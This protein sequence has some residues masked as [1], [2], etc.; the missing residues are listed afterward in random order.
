[1]ECEACRLSFKKFD[2]L[3]ER[4]SEIDRL[5]PNCGC[6]STSVS[7]FSPGVVSDDEVLIRLVIA[8]IHGTS[9]PKPAALQTAETHGLSVFRKKYVSDTE[10]RKRAEELVSNAREGRPKSP[11]SAGLMSVIEMYAGIIRSCSVP[12]ESTPSFCVYDT[13][14]HDIPSHA[15]AFQRMHDVQIAIKS[16]RRTA[17]FNLVKS[18]FVPVSEYR[19]GLLADLAPST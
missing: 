15:E 9:A 13:A 19:Q 7:Q 5:H 4:V 16:L 17:L 14:E 6:Q 2:Q 11:E 10:L 3:K 1:M 12:V 8:P 18:G